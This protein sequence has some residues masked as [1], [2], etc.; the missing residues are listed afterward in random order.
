[1]P[2]AWSGLPRK[3]DQPSARSAS[4]ATKAARPKNW[5]LPSANDAPTRPAQLRGRMPESFTAE[6]SD[7]SFG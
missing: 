5:R 7:G 2:A 4:G 6:K 1:M 3:R